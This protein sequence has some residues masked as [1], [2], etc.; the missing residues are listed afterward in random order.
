M[1]TLITIAKSCHTIEP[2]AGRNYRSHQEK[3]LF[4]GFPRS[5]QGKA[6]SGFFPCLLPRNFFTRLSG[7]FYWWQ[8]Y[9]VFIRLF[10]PVLWLGIISGNYDF[11]WL[12]F[13]GYFPCDTDRCAKYFCLSTYCCKATTPK[14][15]IA[16]F[17]IQIS[18]TAPSSLLSL[19]HNQQPVYLFRHCPPTVRM[20]RWA[21]CGWG[22]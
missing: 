6:K 4:S 8:Q 5:R 7:T 1:G 17:N 16:G 18:N 20:P 13:R 11:F 14:S 15:G 10:F 12:G 2:M 19:Y 3:I 22:Q 9:L 21:K